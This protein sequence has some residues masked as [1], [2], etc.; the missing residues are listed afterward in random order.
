[1][2]SIPILATEIEKALKHVRFEAF[3]ILLNKPDPQVYYQLG[4]SNDGE[5]LVN[6]L[7]F[8][9]KDGKTCLKF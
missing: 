1:M 9:I 6:V 5:N 4:C 7:A 2:G 3:F 8:V